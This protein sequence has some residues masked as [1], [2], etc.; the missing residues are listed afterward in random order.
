MAHKFEKTIL[1]KYDVRGIYGKD[2]HD[3]DAY[4]FGFAYAKRA[5]REFAKEKKFSTNNNHKKEN[6]KQNY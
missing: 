6:K 5:I 4:F 1:R 2:L 3:I